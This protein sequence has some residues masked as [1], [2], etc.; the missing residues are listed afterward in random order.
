MKKS[1]ARRLGWL[2]LALG[3]LMLIAAILLMMLV[4]TIWIAITLFGSVLV[5]TAAVTILRKA[6]PRKRKPRK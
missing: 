4:D 1:A 3:I 2:L 5:N 6:G